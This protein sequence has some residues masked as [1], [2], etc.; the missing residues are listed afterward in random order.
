MPSGALT[1]WQTQLTARLDEL[2]Q[3]HASANG[4]GPGRRWGTE[5]FNGQLFVALVG[6]FQDFARTLH[7]EA[8]D[9]L[10]Q[11]SAIS[12][13]LAE[14]AAR[15][16]RLD[17]GNPSS[18]AL[19]EDFGRIGMK[20][21]A[22]LKTRRHGES[23]LERLDRAVTLRNGIA[24]ADPAK[25][26]AAADPPATALAVAKLSSYRRHRRALNGLAMDID[27]VVAHHLG[28]L[29]GQAPPW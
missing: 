16:R 19:G 28:T 26:A 17:K 8:L 20:F 2:E 27:A 10:R 14:L 12:K 7:D 13:Q 18:G 6:Q 5:Q 4:T 3:V 9:W 15:N 24:H 21:T 23:R 1:Y 29:T 25:I 22:T 11:H